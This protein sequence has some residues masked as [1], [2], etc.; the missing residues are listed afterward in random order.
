MPL[1]DFLVLPRKIF[2]CLSLFILCYY[3]LIPTCFSGYV[4]ITVEN[5]VDFKYRWCFMATITSGVTKEK[6]PGEY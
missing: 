1:L 3:I 6:P 4:S 2:S 5:V